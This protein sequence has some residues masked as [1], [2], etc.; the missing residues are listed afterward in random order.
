MAKDVERDDDTKG[1]KQDK[2]A[3]DRGNTKRVKK[4][5]NGAHKVGDK[6]A[7]NPFANAL[8]KAKK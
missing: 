4:S 2:G 3:N 6:T 8:A 7:G 1:S 5:G